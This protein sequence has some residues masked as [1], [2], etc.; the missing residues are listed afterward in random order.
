MKTMNLS[1]IR[2]LFALVIGLVLVLWPDMA[3][4]YIVITL[5]VA[6]LIPGVVSIVGY[7]AHG[8]SAEKPAPRFPIEGVGSLLFGGWLIVMPGFFVSILMFLL[9]FVLLMGG[10]QQIY[11]L[12]LARRWMHVPAGF[13][14]VPSLILLAGIIALFNPW[15]AINVAFM[16]IG[17][18][19]LVYAV[20]ELVSWFK[21]ARR[22]P[23]PHL[24][25]EDVTDVEVIE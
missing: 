25:A 11:S 4:T 20:S 12:S 19:M 24:D 3:A 17:V 5:G 1:L 15:G 14:V 6:F 10:V 21:F 22:R 18:S 9:G 2:I 7:F 8:K 23:M 13:Y 16:I